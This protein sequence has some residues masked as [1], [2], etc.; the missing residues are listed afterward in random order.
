MNL[1][2]FKSTLSATKVPQD[3]SPCLKALCFDYNGDWE[4]SHNIA[5]SK[6]GTQQYDRLHAYLHRQEGDQWTANYWY[7]RAG[8][9]MPKISW[10]E[11]WE[12]LANRLTKNEVYFCHTIEKQRKRII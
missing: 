8:E 9:T 5:Q 6:E 1:Q 10:E 4:A 7:R 11:E 2:T 12:E 3:I